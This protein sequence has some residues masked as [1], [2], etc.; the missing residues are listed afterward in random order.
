[1]SKKTT[2][3]M[4]GTY[5]ANDYLRKADEIEALCAKRADPRLYARRT[6]IAA[7]LRGM[8]TAPNVAAH[9]DALAAL[10]MI[11]YTAW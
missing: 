10:A 8:A 2:N 5:S 4:A 11:D 9:E 3:P 6:H 7:R 1:M